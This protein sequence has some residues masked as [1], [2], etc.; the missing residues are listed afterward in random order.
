MNGHAGGA[1][2]SLEINEAVADQF[3]ARKA[4]TALFDSVAMLRAP[5]LYGE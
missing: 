2:F 4:T 5:H 1:F 3:S